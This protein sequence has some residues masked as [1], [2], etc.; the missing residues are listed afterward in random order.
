MPDAPSPPLRERLAWQDGAVHDG[1]RRY[2]LMRPDVLMGATAALPDAERQAWLG[3]W[4]ESTRRHGDASLAAYA[5]QAGHDAEALIA[6]TVAAAHDL[7]WGAWT[8]RR[9]G[10]TLQLEVQ[11]SP[12][13]AGW[14]AAAPD[15]PAPQPM[16]APVRGMLAALA[17]RVLWPAGTHSK[18]EVQV[19]E[20]HCAAVAGGPVCRFEARLCA[21]DGARPSEQAA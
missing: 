18:G 11:Q 6:T 8:V 14:Q 20:C 13:A 16:C 3:A 15:R 21:P 10:A 9:H 12:F 7:G 5:Q 2:L 19:D 4:A 1:P 17:A